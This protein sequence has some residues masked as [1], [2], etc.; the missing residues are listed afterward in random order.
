[1]S[2]I[3]YAGRMRNEAEDKKKADEIETG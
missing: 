2:S 3:A 1:L